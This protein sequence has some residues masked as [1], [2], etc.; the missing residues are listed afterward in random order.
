[1]NTKL[2]TVSGV[3]CLSLLRVYT[4]SISSLFFYMYVRMSSSPG[5]IAGVPTSQALPYYCTSICVRSCYTW[6][7][8]CV[9]PK[10]EKKETKFEDNFDH[11]LFIM[12]A[13]TFQ[14]EI[15]M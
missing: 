1:M 11:E 12:R 14:K 5:S 9:D 6:R 15:F 8:G 7:A 13:I 2:F 4:C 3:C 10:R